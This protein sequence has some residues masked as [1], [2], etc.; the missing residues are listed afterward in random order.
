MKNVILFGAMGAGKDTVANML[1]FLAEKHNKKEYDYAC[2]NLKLSR[3]IYCIIRDLTGREPTRK[4]LQ[5]LG[6]FCRKLFGNNVWNETLYADIDTFLND[7][8]VNFI[9]TDGRQAHELDFWKK[10]GFVPIGVAAPLEERLKRIAERD[11]YDQTDRANHETEAR[12]LETVN[13]C[14]IIIYN[15]GTIDELRDK[16]REVYW[17]FLK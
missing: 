7:P 12:A 9:I 8:A 11:G 1:Q 6:E 14:D 3:K 4:E 15:D 17:N 2:V 13:H 10:K 16:V 5:E